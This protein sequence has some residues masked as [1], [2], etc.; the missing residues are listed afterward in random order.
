MFEVSNIDTVFF[1]HEGNHLA[2]HTRPTYHY[3]LLLGKRRPESCAQICESYMETLRNMSYAILEI[4]PCIQDDI[5][6][7]TSGKEFFE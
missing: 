4:F 1:E 5:I 7:M 3:N 6:S 2:T